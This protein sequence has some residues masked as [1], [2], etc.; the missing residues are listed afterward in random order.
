MLL[1]PEQSYSIQYI[2]VNGAVM[3]LLI[4]QPRS[5]LSYRTTPYTINKAEKYIYISVYIH[6]GVRTCTACF[7][8]AAHLSLEQSAS[9]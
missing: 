6:F 4:L 8:G 5:L 2:R 1:E 7:G 3:S 9:C